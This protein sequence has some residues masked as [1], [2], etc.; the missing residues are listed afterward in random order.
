MAEVKLVGFK[1]GDKYVLS[2]LYV[3][4]EAAVLPKGWAVVSRHKSWEAANAA[5]QRMQGAK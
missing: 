1:H 3:F 5:R 2:S 4:M